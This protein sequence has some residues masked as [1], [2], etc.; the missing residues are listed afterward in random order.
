[1][2]IL[3]IIPA[4]KPAYAY[5]GPTRSTA[6]LC[7]ALAEAGHDIT[8]FA[9]NANGEKNLDVIEES[10]IMVD[11]VKVFYHRRWTKDQ[12]NFSP[13]L[14]R[15]FWREAGSFDVVHLHAWWNLVVIPALW[16]CR[17][18]SI[19][20]VISTRGTLSTFTFQHSRSTIKKIIHH[21]FG[22]R[23]ISE[24]ILHVTSV[25]ERNELNS[26]LIHPDIMVIPNLIEFPRFA[27][28]LPLG[29]NHF[30]ILYL[31]R[32]HP[33][34]NL[35]FI[36]KVLENQPGF[37]FQLH[38]IGEGNEDYVKRL[39][40]LSS[41]NP[42]VNW[43]KEMN[44]QDKWKFIQQ[45]DL[46]VLPSKTENFANV[47]IEALSQGTPVLISDQVGLKDF[48]LENNLGWVEKLDIGSWRNRL[49]QIW[50]NEVERKRIRTEAPDIIRQQFSTTSLIG[51]YEK[52]YEYAMKS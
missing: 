33:V 2:K 34:K 15:R 46:L 20:T 7:E 32:F 52:L 44:D 23:W 22:R 27:D 41:S 1:M 16:I 12:S 13:G 35:E 9:T 48:V 39:K 30:H 50:N 42:N 29:G 31:G 6:R 4:Y 37:P 17:K 40:S 10:Q 47:V 11:G 51:Q 49:F 36:L 28:I 25:K 21:L 45:A 26:V 3:H 8:V 18:K 24:A 14:L 19:K 43:Y 38:L 5:G